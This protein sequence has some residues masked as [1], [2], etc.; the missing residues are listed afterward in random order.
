MRKLK[1]FSIIFLMMLISI[2]SNAT[3][4]EIKKACSDYMKSS[5]S[6]IVELKNE[7]AMQVELLKQQDSSIAQ[8]QGITAAMDKELNS[9]HRDPVNMI[10]IGLFVGLATGIAVSK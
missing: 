7:N 1:K 8:L 6:Y 9:F 2:Q 3:C 10:F 4:E 5:D